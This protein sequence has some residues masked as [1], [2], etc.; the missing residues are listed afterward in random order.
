MC[1]LNI[2]EYN[3]KLTYTFTGNG[4]VLISWT[5]L[6]VLP[7]LILSITKTDKKR[8]IEQMLKVKSWESAGYISR[9]EQEHYFC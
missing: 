4:D 1:Y 6:S 3:V 5:R 2:Q 9:G 7:S 8:C